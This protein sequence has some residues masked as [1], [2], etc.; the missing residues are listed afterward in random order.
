MPEQI[1]ILAILDMNEVLNVLYR[2]CFRADPSTK[3]VNGTQVH[4]SRSFWVFCFH[5]M[6][7]LMKI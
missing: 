1:L 7:K 3:V 5:L 6:Q 4:D 2:L